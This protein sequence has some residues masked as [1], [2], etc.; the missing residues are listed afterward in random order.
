MSNNLSLCHPDEQKSCFACCPPIRPAGYEHIQYKNII[1]RELR[2]N[3]R[4]FKKDEETIRPITGFNCWALGYLDGNFKRIGC[5]LHPRRNKGIDLRFRIDYGEKCHR[6]SCVEEKIFSQLDDFVKKFWLNIAN[7]LDSFTYSSRKENP[8][9]KMLGWG[10]DLLHVIASEEEGNIFDISSFFKRYPFFE[11]FENSLISRGNA[12]LLNYIICVMG[13]GILKEVTFATA[14]KQF[15]HH[16][17]HIVSIKHKYSEKEIPIHLLDID[18][19]FADFL[20]LSPKV[21]KSSPDNAA[22]LKRIVDNE[23]KRSI[24]YL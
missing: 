21:S 11:F 1:K 6:E 5:L 18:R 23:L 12:Y 20:R 9:F 15:S 16:I 13:I 10:G 17:S 8:L 4:V 22:A 7:G 19:Y 14:F 2:E 3:S 24:F